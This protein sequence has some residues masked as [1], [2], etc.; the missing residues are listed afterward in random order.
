MSNE[1]EY[2]DAALDGLLTTISIFEVGGFS[3]P[4]GKQQSTHTLKKVQNVENHCPYMLPCLLRERI[5]LPTLSGWTFHLTL[6]LSLPCLANLVLLRSLDF[7]KRQWRPLVSRPWLEPLLLLAERDLLVAVVAMVVVVAEMAGVALVV[8]VVMVHLVAVTA[9][10]G[11]MATAAVKAAVRRTGNGQS[12]GGN[13]GKGLGAGDAQQG[14]AQQHPLAYNTAA[15]FCQMWDNCATNVARQNLEQQALTRSQVGEVQFAAMLKYNVRLHA[16]I[17]ALTGQVGANQA[18]ATHANVVAANA[19]A[20]ARAAENADRF[21][22]AAP[23]KY[24]NKKKDA[25]VK[26]W[27]PIIEDY[28][29]T[30]LDADYIRLSS[31]YLKDGLRSLWTSVYEAYKAAN[32]GAKHPSPWVFFHETIENNYGLQNLEQKHWDTWNSL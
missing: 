8:T 23:F 11:A 18:A 7:S 29:R 27:I 28:L 13:G 24:G 15:Q 1:K 6:F 5:R 26:Q 19:Q 2:L 14:G 4:V 17:G 20:V 10:A 30:A 25:D 12:S 9:P 16:T 32:G 31:S 21:R 3:T 22:L